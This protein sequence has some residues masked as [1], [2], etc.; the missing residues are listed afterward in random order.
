MTG[1][2]LPSST[3]AT[4][5]AIQNTNAKSGFSIVK[6][7]MGE[8]LR[9]WI[10]RHA[11]PIIAKELKAG[12]VVRIMGDAD[13]FKQLTDKVVL[14]STMEA[15]DEAFAS[16]HLPTYDEVLQAIESEKQK[17]QSKD[18]FMELIRDV[19]ANE[20]ETEVYVTNDEMD[21][22]VRIQNLISMLNFAPEYK[23]AI[24]KQ[25]FDLMGL[26][27]PA[28]QQQPQQMNAGN[29]QIPMPPSAQ[30]GVVP[31]PNSGMATGAEQAQR[32][33]TQAMTGK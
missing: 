8:F 23:D 31:L 20:L 19:I 10:D 33:T 15:L 5:A 14:S 25:T 16:G 24:V 18:M 28:T 9:R 2:A 21:I 6:S 12:Q 3:P 4:N 22:S 32:L 26:N 30:G 13:S 7:N 29:T 27:M 1:E 11:L 17:I